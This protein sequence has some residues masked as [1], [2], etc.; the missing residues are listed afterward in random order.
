ML[1]YHSK[2]QFIHQGWIVDYLGTRHL[3]PLYLEFVHLCCLGPAFCQYLYW[4][5]LD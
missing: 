5:L 1:L 2:A 4:Y 3:H